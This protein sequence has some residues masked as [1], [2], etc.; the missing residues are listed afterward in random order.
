MINV[1]AFAVIVLTVI[2]VVL[3]QRL[4]RD[5]GILRPGAT[6]AATAK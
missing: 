1:V 2:P 3:A 4:T 5:T 6:A